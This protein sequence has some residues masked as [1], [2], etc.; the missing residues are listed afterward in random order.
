VKESSLTEETSAGVI[1]Y[2]YMVHRP[3]KPRVSL[4]RVSIMLP[5]G[6]TQDLTNGFF[7]GNDVVLSDE[8]RARMILKAG[9]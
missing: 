8:L 2:C 5:N 4:L 1:T 9:E 6:D 3:S 7:S